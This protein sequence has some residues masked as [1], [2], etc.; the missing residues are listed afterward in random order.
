MTTTDANMVDDSSRNRETIKGAEASKN[1]YDDADDDHKNSKSSK[2][3]N[4]VTNSEIQNDPNPRLRRPRRNLETSSATSTA[5]STATSNTDVVVSSLAK[6]L[7]QMAVEERQKAMYD[8]HGLPR[9]DER[10][11]TM[12][13]LLNEMDQ[14]IEDR[15]QILK[16]SFV[17]GDNFGEPDLFPLLTP[18]QQHEL[19]LVPK[20]TPTAEEDN[21][22]DKLREGV[23][24]SETPVIQQ[25]IQFLKHD[26]DDKDFGEGLRLA[27]AQNPEYVHAQRIKFLRADQYDAKLASSRLIRFFDIKR[28]LFCNPEYNKNETADVHECL[29]R[30]LR[31]SD[32]SKE[33][34]ELWR[35]TGF[36]QLC[37]MRDRAKRPIAVIFGKVIME[38]NIPTDLVLRAYMYTCN[39]WSRDESTQRAGLV[40]IAYN[41]F[42]SASPSKNPVSH[43]APLASNEDETM[44]GNSENSAIK[45]YLKKTYPL[46]SLIIKVGMSTQL[47]GVSMHFCIDHHILKSQFEKIAGYMSTASAARFRCHHA[48]AKQSESSDNSGNDDRGSVTDSQSSQHESGKETAL[49]SS[50]N[51]HQEVLYTLMTFG[52]PKGTIPINDNTGEVQLDLHQATFSAIEKQEELDRSMEKATMSASTISSSTIESVKSNR[53]KLLSSLSSSTASNNLW[54]SLTAST[55]SSGSFALFPNLLAE[56]ELDDVSD[57]SATSLIGAP[58]PFDSDLDLNMDDNLPDIASS[59]SSPHLGQSVSHSAGPAARKAEEPSP[60]PSGPIIVPTAN[61]VIMGRG[62]WNR[63]NAGNLRLK[64][65]IERERDQYDYAN[66]FERMRIVDGMLNELFDD[67]GARFLY[68]PKGDKSVAKDLWLVAKR[69]KAHDKITHDFRNLRRQKNGS[70]K[71]TS[72]AISNRKS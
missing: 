68:K 36:M 14:S 42:T 53:E 39:I 71:S 2:R 51:P 12:Q 11:E 18:E 54:M 63:N 15:L 70:T 47:R 50:V 43:T 30:D 28:E 26:L 41:M 21:L 44:G 62:P 52:I 49:D 72:P 5:T 24:N 13:K 33:D 6:R 29:G 34:L 32:F 27:R 7:T 16:S 67:F 22:V 61:D 3:S 38:A 48:S 8:L 66:R 10:P 58:P 60:N 17:D 64:A 46:H 9:D 19:M 35:K 37:G 23:D 69:D 45:D 65:M 40:V 59:F 4:F 1:R 55:G 57:Q 31:L 25:R 56:E 20:M